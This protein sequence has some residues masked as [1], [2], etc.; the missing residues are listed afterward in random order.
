[1]LTGVEHACISTGVAVVVAGR[2]ERQR[3]SLK[4]CIAVEDRQAQQLMTKQRLL[5]VSRNCKI[6]HYLNAL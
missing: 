3:G 2:E 5:I 6:M 4:G 1:M